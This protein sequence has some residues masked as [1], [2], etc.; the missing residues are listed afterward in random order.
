[1]RRG[2]GLF[3]FPSA[4][5]TEQKLTATFGSQ[6]PVDNF[7]SL[8][9]FC[10]Y[11]WY[12]WFVWQAGQMLLSNSTLE[13]ITMSDNDWIVRT[14][15]LCCFENHFVVIPSHSTRVTPCHSTSVTPSHA[16][17]ATP[18]HS[19]SVT[20]S[21][22]TRVTP[23]HSTSVT[24]SHATRATPSRITRITPSRSTSHSV[25]LLVSLQVTTTVTPNHS[26]SYAE[27][28]Y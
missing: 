27:W 24:P 21:H 5:N 13:M 20:P 2:V 11:C 28:L 14:S 1:M 4:S 17:R 3:T 22:S 19:T 15:V 12:K 16:T 7:V 25:T 18:C 23:C 8:L 6:L 9:I 26:T 10:L